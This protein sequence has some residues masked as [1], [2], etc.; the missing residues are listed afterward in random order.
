MENQCWSRQYQEK[1]TQVLPNISKEKCA[2]VI[3]V[4]YQWADLA[5]LLY[6]VQVGSYNFK[7]ARDWYSLKKDGCRGIKHNIVVLTLEWR[8]CALVFYLLST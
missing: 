6:N 1:E 3:P 2:L 7:T 4:V 8:W 5:P